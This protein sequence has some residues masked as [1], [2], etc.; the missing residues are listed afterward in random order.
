MRRDAIQ[1]CDLVQLELPGFQKLA[2]LR[3][4]S[5]LL[6]LHPFFQYR[7][8]M[9]IAAAPVYFVPGVPY[10]LRIFQNSRMLQDT[11]WC[12]TVGKETGSILFTGKGNPHSILH[13]SNRGIAYQSIKTKSWDMQHIIPAKCD[14][15]IA[16]KVRVFIRVTGIGINKLPVPIT[17]H[18]HLACQQRIKR[19]HTAC[20]IPDN[21]GIGIPP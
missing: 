14:L 1:P 13:H 18:C 20:S 8:F 21:L 9:G 7:Y 19:H 11:S 17:V 6:I 12:G 2:V 5:D 10:F 15:P 16:G 4:Q 3:R